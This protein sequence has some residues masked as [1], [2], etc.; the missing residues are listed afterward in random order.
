[1]EYAIFREFHDVAREWVGWGNLP[2]SGQERA[3]FLA[4]HFAKQKRSEAEQAR[5]GVKNSAA[6]T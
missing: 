4:A 2:A 3:S 5:Y 1:M 6:E